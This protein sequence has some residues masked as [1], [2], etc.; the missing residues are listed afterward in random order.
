M[1]RAI[2]LANERVPISGIGNIRQR[3]GNLL[4]KSHAFWGTIKSGVTPFAEHEQ[5]EKAWNQ[6]GRVR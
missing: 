1:A 3:I 4:S 6:A 5:S 2:L